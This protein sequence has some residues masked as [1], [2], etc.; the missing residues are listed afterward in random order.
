MTMCLNTNRR[1][2][3]LFSIRRTIFAFLL[4]KVHEVVHQLTLY[5]NEYMPYLRCTI[6]FNEVTRQSFETFSTVSNY[7]FIRNNFHMFLDGIPRT[8]IML[9]F[10]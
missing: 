3:R 10:V 8:Y 7:E 9:N 6:A 1:L 4:I 2:I 5:I